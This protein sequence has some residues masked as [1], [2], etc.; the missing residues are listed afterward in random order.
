MSQFLGKSLAN[1]KS[2]EFLINEKIYS[3]SIHCLYYSTFQLILYIT[4]Y[5]LEKEWVSY[6]D[7]KEAELH[8]GGKKEE[9]HNLTITFIK[10]N[11]KNEEFE[12]QFSKNIG[13]LKKNRHTSDYKEDVIDDKIAETSLKLS[14][15]INDQLIKHFNL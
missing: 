11:I 5:K 4:K 3:S 10:E 6:Q 9:S 2:A 1:F 14:Q 15:N 7:S 8:N 12:R 13:I